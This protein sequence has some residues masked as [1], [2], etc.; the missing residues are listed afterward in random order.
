MATERSP[1]VDSASS[2]EANVEDQHYVASEAF[3]QR[4]Y[5]TDAGGTG[6]THASGVGRHIWFPHCERSDRGR[7]GFYQG[8][9]GG[10]RSKKILNDHIL[11]DVI[12]DNPCQILCAQE[13]GPELANIMRDAKHKSRPAPGSSSSCAPA[14]AGKSATA[15][16]PIDTAWHVVEGEPGAKSTLMVAAKVSFANEVKKLE[17]HLIN[18]GAKP[19]NSRAISRILVAEVVLKDPFCSQA[20]WWSAVCT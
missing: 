7:F 11:R 17:W 12:M 5:H 2:A 9:W 3:E 20:Q 18:N 14:P 19:G 10:H 8:N 16:E 6:R 4:R 1:S 15:S 13:T